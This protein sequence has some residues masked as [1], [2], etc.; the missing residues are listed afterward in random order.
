MRSADCVVDVE[1]MIMGVLANNVYIVS[2]GEGT[3]VVDPQL[4]G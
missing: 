1:Y 3:M 4:L 2:D